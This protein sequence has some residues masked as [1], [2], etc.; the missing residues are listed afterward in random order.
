[1]VYGAAPGPT[2]PQNRITKRFDDRG[3]VMRTAIAEDGRAFVN[4]KMFTILV[5]RR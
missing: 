1:L 4:C 2:A 3:L 5:K